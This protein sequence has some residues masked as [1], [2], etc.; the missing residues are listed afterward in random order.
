M[1][2]L[3]SYFF[4]GIIFTA[5]LGLTVYI[6]FLIFKFVDGTL[7][8]LFKQYLQVTIPGLGILTVIIF[9]V[10]LGYLGQTIIA[11]P[12][13]SILNNLLSRAP[14]VKTLYSSIK[15]FLSAFVGKEKRF[16]KPVL[17]K[18]SYTSELQKLGFLTQDD[19]KE[20]EIRDKVAVYFPHSYNF[21][22]ELFIVPRELVKPLDLPPAEIMK[23]IVSGGVTSV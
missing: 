3:I 20:F 2:K 14:V 18:V 22:G 8:P 15:D 16:N 23:F 21:S 10:L 11:R 19:L 7:Q 12:F 1:K 5:P 9:L 13:R 6:L 4:Q 17:V